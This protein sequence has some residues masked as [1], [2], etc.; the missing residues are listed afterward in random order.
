MV[1]RSRVIE[2]IADLVK[3]KKIDGITAIND[4]MGKN[5]TPR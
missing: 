4:T 1:F 2:N 3:D 5:P